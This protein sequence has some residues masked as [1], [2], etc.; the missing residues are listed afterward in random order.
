MIKL[1]QIEIKNENLVDIKPNK[2]I[3]EE[4]NQAKKAVKTLLKENKVIKSFSFKRRI[5]TKNEKQ[6]ILLKELSVPEHLSFWVTPLNRKLS[7]HIV[8]FKSDSL[9]DIFLNYAMLLE[10]LMELE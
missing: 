1:V 10:R 8:W 6:Q 4:F 9:D 2:N 7:E 5:V 3:T